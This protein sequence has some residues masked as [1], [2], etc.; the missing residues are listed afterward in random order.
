MRVGL[1]IREERLSK[2]MTLKALSEKA[3]ISLSFLSDIERG[4]SNPSL[5]RLQEISDA[6]NCKVSY[7]LEHTEED[8]NIFNK[9]NLLCY[10]TDDNIR[11]RICKLMENQDFVKIL[12]EFEGFEKWTEGEKAELVSMLR[13]KRE[14]K[15]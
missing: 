1:R 13:T 11:E 9:N 8:D 15:K 2:K 12:L 5:E 6:L 4:R 3:D 10:E 14:F 7:L